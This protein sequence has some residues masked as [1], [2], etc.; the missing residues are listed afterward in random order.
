M[1]EM[2]EKSVP[3]EVRRK[4]RHVEQLRAFLKSG[5]E[6]VQL[7]NVKAAEAIREYNGLYQASKRPEFKGLMTVKRY[8]TDIYL[9]RR[10]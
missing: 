2:I 5:K 4:R 8:G 9:L 1:Y 10:G 7:R 6:S 3:T